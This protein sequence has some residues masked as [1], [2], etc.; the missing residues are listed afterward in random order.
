MAH[1]IAHNSRPTRLVRRA[2]ALVV[3][4]A[5]MG[6]SAPGFA[7]TYTV[8]TTQNSGA[9]SLRQAILDA[10]A[11]GAP[12]GVVG[13]A[14]IIN[15]T[16][17]GTISLLDALPLV[18]SN[19]TIFG[20]GI[21]IDGGSAHRC[22]FVNGLPTTPTGTP[23]TIAVTLHQLH[24]NHCRAKGGDGGAGSASG[25]GG[26]M[27]AGGA[28][29]VGQNASV[30]L[31]Q[32]S[33]DGN[34]STGGNGGVAG[35]SNAGGGGGG[36]LGG[37]GGDGPAGA[38]GSGGGIGGSGGQSSTSARGG[39]GGIGG[40]GGDASP[41]FPGGGGGGGF[42]GTGVGQIAP[43]QGLAAAGSSTE[44]GSGGGN[45]GGGG[46]GTNGAAG[47]A[48]GLGGAGGSTAGTGGGGGA[49][50]GSGV[51]GIGGGGGG[52]SGGIG[53]GGDGGYGG[54]GSAYH[55][56][57]FG[58]GG[59]GSDLISVG[60]AG[61]FGGGGGG[62]DH[63][64]DQGG[65][66]GF[67]GGGGGGYYSGNGGFGGSIGG[68]SSIAA[69]G[70]G[71]AAMGAAI[72]VVNG[73][74]LSVIGAGNLANG[75]LTPGSAGGTIYGNGS[76]FGS[77]L[78]LQG[79]GTLT[80]NLP[81][82]AYTINDDV[83]DATGSGATG[84]DAGS[85]GIHVQG[86]SLILGGNNTYTGPTNID[87]GATLEVNGT[88]TGTGITINPGG[89]VGG[90]GVVANVLNAGTV[91]PGN[92]TTPL[93]M[94][95]AQ[96]YNEVA[97]NGSTLRIAANAAGASASLNVSANADLHGKV[98]FD[99]SGGPAPGTTY[100][101]ANVA[102]TINQ[103]F[104][105]YDSNMPSV[106]GEIVYLPHSIQFTVIANDLVFRSG[107]EIGADVG[108][109][110]YGAVSAAQFATLPA[111]AIDGQPLCIP[112]ISYT[113]FGET[114]TGCQSPS[115]CAP[116]FPSFPGCLAVL[117]AQTGTLGGSLASGAYSVD[118]PAQID[119][120]SVPVTFSGPISG[121]CTMD[122]SGTAGRIVPV[123]DAEP[124]TLNGVQNGAYLYAMPSDAVN[125]LTTS[126]SGCG[127]ISAYANQF[128][129]YFEAQFAAAIESAA[130][131]TLQ[132]V[133][134]GQTICPAP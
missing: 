23:Q 36:G 65:S 119:P 54:G 4:V 29:F 61:G 79:Y 110:R 83:A 17:S 102:G 7:T 125:S 67:G 130:A 12:A 91:A 105:G 64:S 99:F 34:L 74:A 70:G 118:T 117:R 24:L 33:F 124:E 47:V 89:V 116:T 56:G 18:F 108:A 73:G 122:F 43:N 115:T 5:F 78:F 37:A 126:Q 87:S 53:G 92:A 28:L 71:A 30:T 72:F 129:P 59:G 107:F 81:G 50:G 46:G 11:S 111:Q 95:T 112:P 2:L 132:Q 121:S 131:P 93:G 86:G 60:P 103:S 35:T 97:P 75:V 27:G 26:G 6:A 120:L 21:T 40:N 55:A 45:G 68:P 85:W 104:S 123:Y 82:L 76:A 32:I 14:N 42:G 13:I 62:V 44:G 88:T 57:G 51:G 16:T 77:G 52:S 98:H 128:L 1:S 49:G 80:F 100:T 96:T 10:N 90:V 69:Y 133:G 113:Y 106:F 66:G 38:Y 3:A 63:Q 22:L 48:S 94:F 101:F 41:S 109:C 114:I 25:G 8:S 58:G 127:V 31:A 15:V 20:N 39:G 9:G 19:L 134:V 84:A